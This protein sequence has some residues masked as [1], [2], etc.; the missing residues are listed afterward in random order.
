MARRID[1][2]M[3]EGISSMDCVGLVELYPIGE[4]LVSVIIVF[5]SLMSTDT[6]PLSCVGHE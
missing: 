2:S 4:Y 5:C 6:N 3:S 1:S